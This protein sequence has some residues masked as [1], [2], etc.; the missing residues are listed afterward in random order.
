MG[1]SEEK[2]GCTMAHVKV[3]QDI[4]EEPRTSVQRVCGET[5]DYR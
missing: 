5:E 1:G 2:G 4:H 3:I